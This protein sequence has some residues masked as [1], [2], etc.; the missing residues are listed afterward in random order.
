MAPVLFLSEFVP[1]SAAYL[2]VALQP[3]G[4]S[5]SRG[6]GTAQVVH[7]EVIIST[8]ALRPRLQ[9]IGQKSCL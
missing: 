1:D 3:I 2:R 7:S 5:Y 8:V 6:L 4:G 9:S